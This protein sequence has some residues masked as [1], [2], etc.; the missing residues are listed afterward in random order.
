MTHLPLADE[1]GHIVM[2]RKSMS[3]RSTRTRRYPRVVLGVDIPIA[4]D[5]TR[6]RDRS[7]GLMTV[8]SAGGACLEVS[9]TFP[10]DSVVELRFTLPGPDKEI[11]CCGLVRHEAPGYGIG[12]TFTQLAAPDQELIREA[13]KTWLAKE[14]VLCSS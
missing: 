3:A 8:L 4:T 10:I 7:R 12:V 2:A 6:G 1:N 11:A 5:V 13:V 9:G 14:R